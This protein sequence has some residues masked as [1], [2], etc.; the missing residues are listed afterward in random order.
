MA[1]SKINDF[2]KTRKK[3][4]NA[5]IPYYKKPY[6]TVDKQ[7]YQIMGNTLII[8]VRPGRPYVGI[9]LNDYT[10]SQFADPHIKIGAITITRNTIS[11]SISKETQSIT[12]TEFVG[13][14]TNLNNISTVH[15]D[16]HVDVFSDVAK[17]TKIKQKYRKVKSHFRR[18]D[19][20]I[21]KK[22]F[23]KY[24]TKQQHK[25]K[26]TL[27]NIS[28]KLVTQKK[29]LILEDLK[30]IRK[31][32][33]KGNGQG[34]KYRSRLNGWP[35]YEFKRQLEYKSKWYNG[36]PVIKIK[37]NKTS[38]KCSICGAKVIPEEN[39]QIRCHCGHR[40]DRDINAARNILYK[41]VPVVQ[42]RGLR[43]RPDAPQGEAMKQS[44][45]AKQIVTSQINLQ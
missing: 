5:K 41:G 20:R 11:I 7:S 28:K 18:N 36:I 40:E 24:G 9:P 42:L 27:H 3:N 22:I 15:S 16:G 19:V 31:L 43:L 29:Q 6:V 14:D 8:G 34:T 33:Q 1:K 37:P 25:T 30:G 35:F 10:V 4:P 23:Q 32:Y 17:I 13:I 12:P 39:R 45:D 38:S 2:R 21:G 26:Q 44:K